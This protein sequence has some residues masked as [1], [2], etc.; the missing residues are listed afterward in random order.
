VAF[1]DEYK[2]ETHYAEEFAMTKRALIW[3]SHF[4]FSTEHVTI[5]PVDG[6]WAMRGTAIA[7]FDDLPA[8]ITYSIGCDPAWMMRDVLVTIEHGAAS[9]SVALSAASGR[10]T[11]DGNER[12]DL[13]GCTDI[14]LGITPFTN[15]LPIRRLDLAVGASA[16]ASAAWVRFPDLAVERLDQ[17]YTR[18]AGDRYRYESISG[19]TAELTVDDFGIVREYGDLWSLAA[20]Q[21]S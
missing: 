4:Q 7:I 13:G 10:W 8:L 5:K 18:L 12:S 9:R 15:T 6:G 3:T 1:S 11:V 17:T 21:E 16:P 14:D 2:P 19:F 20:S